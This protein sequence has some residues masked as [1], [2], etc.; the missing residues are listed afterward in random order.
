MRS[1]EREEKQK[2][3]YHRYVFR[4]GRLVGQFEQ[5]YRGSKVVPWRQDQSANTWWADIAVRML[6]VRAPYANAI[7]VGCGLGYFTDKFSRLCRSLVGADVSPTA[8]MKAKATFPALEFRV[9]DVRKPVRRLSSFD[10]VVVKDIFW[11]VFPKLDQVVQNLKKMTAPGGRLFIF[12]SFPNLDQPFI[13]K[14]AISNPERLLEYFRESFALEYSCHCQDHFRA[15]EGPMFMA[16]LRKK[17][18]RGS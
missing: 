18:R 2:D 17:R 3:D 6:E 16:L 4:D 12:Q 7:E 14:E 1:A 10:L 8:V 15:Q 13:G 9:F 11:Y 5:M